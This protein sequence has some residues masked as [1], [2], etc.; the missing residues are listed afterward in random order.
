VRAERHRLRRREL[1]EAVREPRQLRVG[2]VVRR[3][4]ERLRGDRDQRVEGVPCVYG[5]A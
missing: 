5:V 3:E 2:A 4:R 1:A